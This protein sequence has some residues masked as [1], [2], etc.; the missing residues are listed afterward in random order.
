MHL[1]NAE[2]WLFSKHEDHISLNNTKYLFAATNFS[3]ISDSYYL[4]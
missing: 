4:F 2:Y 3:R 1:V